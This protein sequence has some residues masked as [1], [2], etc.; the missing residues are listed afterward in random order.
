MTVRAR[1]DVFKLLIS[2]RLP[3]TPSTT[4]YVVP[5]YCPKLF[6]LRGTYTSRPYRGSVTA[7]RYLPRPD[8]WPS[9]C[10]RVALEA[11]RVAPLTRHL[12]PRTVSPRLSSS[13]LAIR[14]DARRIPNP[15][16]NV[17]PPPAPS[18]RPPPRALCDLR[19]R[20]S[21]VPAHLSPARRVSRRTSRRRAP[22]RRRRRERTRARTPPWLARTRA[23]PPPRLLHC[24]CLLRRARRIEAS[25]PPPPPGSPASS[26]LR[27]PFARRPALGEVF[28]RPLPPT[29]LRESPP[30]RR[31]RRA[32]RLAGRRDPPRAQ[33]A[34]VRARRAQP[35]RARHSAWLN[36]SG[37]SRL[38]RKN[39]VPRPSRMLHLPTKTSRTRPSHARC[40]RTAT[41]WPYASAR[42]RTTRSHERRSCVQAHLA[43]CPP[44][45]RA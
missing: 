25:T 23:S 37:S 41:A 9:L 10:L 21:R 2:I 34:C 42:Y 29:R 44:P 40:H 19:S 30:W 24:F 6:L 35:R 5:N 43:R 31:R 33:R 16:V 26:P 28:A 13:S 18:P 11:A 20:L 38:G 14:N 22:A 27:V 1:R 4:T 45:P 12:A 7:E 32:R 3:R 36:A 17:S 39:R 15:R 8:A